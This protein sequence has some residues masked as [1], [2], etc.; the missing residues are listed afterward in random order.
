MPLTREE[1]KLLHQK[2]KQ[3]TFGSGKPDSKEGNEGDIS[4]RQVE[5]SGTVEYVKTNG[6]WVAVASSGEMPAVRIVGG[7]G[8]SST[9]TGVTSHGALSGL[10]DDD[11][12][13]YLL[14]DGSRAMTGDL[15][16]NG[17][18]ISIE[19][20]AHDGVGK[21]LT[22]SAG[23]T[24]AGTTNNIAGGALTFEGGKGKGS[25][26]GG[27]IIFKTANASG[28]GSSLNAL[29][30]ALTISD[31]LS[32]TFAGD[33]SVGD[34]LLFTSSGAVINWNSGDVTLTHSANT[35]TVAGGT[36]A[37]AAITGTT[38]DAST[39]F[40]IGGTV[41]TAN[42]L[43]MIPSVDDSVTISAAS[44]GALNIVTV[45]TAAAAGHI[46]ITADGD[47]SLKA[48]G[49]RPGIVIDGTSR[50]IYINEYDTSYG[51]IIT[52]GSTTVAANYAEYRL[53]VLGDTYFYT[54]GEG[55]FEQ[56]YSML[57]SHE[58]VASG[59]TYPGE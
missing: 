33:V 29:A 25:G 22:I 27:D 39:D 50:S 13:Q 12:T 40:T 46:T 32:A 20:N 31:D 4:F 9:I 17:G 8:G 44:N 49:A 21:S 36:F 42:Q 58:E 38:I 54:Q 2:S 45:D 6:D 26:A 28:S 30:T 43:L 47:L 57:S 15:N 7:S 48:A 11:H 34:D 35:I 3:P 1:R 53:Q 18:D 5:G 56:N 19:D 51:T 16:V 14:I 24:T 59:V 52:H 23:D 10:T 55:D 41:M 37:A